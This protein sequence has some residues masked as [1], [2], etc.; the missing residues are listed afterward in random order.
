ML[1]LGK[2]SDDKGTQLEKL[3]EILLAAKGYRSIT[4]NSIGA[5]GAEIDVR[6]DR[7]LPTLAG[8]KLFRMICECKAHKEPVGLTYWLKF[9]GKIYVERLTVNSD[10]LGCFIA[11]RGVNG[12]VR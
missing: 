4:R 3:T 8:N 7:E 5:G 2:S 1:V 6:G 12:N 10:T 11:L 9:C